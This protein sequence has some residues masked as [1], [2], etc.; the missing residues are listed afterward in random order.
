MYINKID[1]LIDNI[2]DDFYN[3]VILKD[4]NFSKFLKEPNFVRFQPQINKMLT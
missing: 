4:K 3:T 1:E 2:I